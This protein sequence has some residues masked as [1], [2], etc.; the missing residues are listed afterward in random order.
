MINAHKLN[1]ASWPIACR[2]SL[3]EPCSVEVGG[4][5][6]REREAAFC[7]GFQVEPRPGRISE[8]L[9]SGSSIRTDVA[10]GSSERSGSKRRCEFPHPVE[11]RQPTSTTPAHFRPVHRHQLT[12]FYSPRRITSSAAEFPCAPISSIKQPRR[13]PFM[14]DLG[15]SMVPRVISANS[16][17]L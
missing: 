4:C 15:P 1:T 7:Q 10:V 6:E 3:S 12:S 5:R 17:L 16:S 11:P 14:S 13:S 2:H 9:A 8:A